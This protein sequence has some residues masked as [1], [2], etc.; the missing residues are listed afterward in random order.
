MKFS[1]TFSFADFR[2]AQRLHIRQKLIRRINIYIWPVLAIVLLIGLIVFSNTDH[3]ELATQCVIFGS[4]SLWLTIFLPIARYFN[5]R[6]GFKRVFLSGQKDQQVSIDIDNE[7]ILS[8]IPG[9]GEGK[10]FWNTIVG[11]AQ[12]NK[13]TLLYVYKDRFLVF[14]TALLSSEQ[15]TELNELV[16]RNMVRKEK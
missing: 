15:R 2:A 4:L 9:V 7:R 5:A 14:P 1:Y 3:Q 16:S 11:F 8:E 6:K 13:V 12:D 10:Y